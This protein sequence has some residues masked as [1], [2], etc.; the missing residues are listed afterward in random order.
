MANDDKPA[1][2]QI[3]G[4]VSG[5]VSGPVAIGKDIEQRQQVG[6]MN[7]AVTEADLGELRSEFAKLREQVAAGAPPEVREKALEMVDQL[8]GDTV[9]EK[10]K[11]VTMRYVLDWF[12][13]NAPKLAGAVTSVVIHPIVGRLV[14][15]AGEAVTGEFKALLGR[16]DER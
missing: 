7:I 2:D 8:E 13:D 11:P 6:E 12:K 4:V 14:E 16:S 9:S 15:A 5:T 3:H 10:P 1:G